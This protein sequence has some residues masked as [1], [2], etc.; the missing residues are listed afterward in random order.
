MICYVE[1]LLREGLGLQDSFE[2]WVERAHHALILKPPSEA[3]PRSTVAKMS[4]L[5]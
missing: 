4:S 3:P 2:L 5:G 1:H